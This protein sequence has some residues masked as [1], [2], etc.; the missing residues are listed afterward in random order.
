MEYRLRYRDIPWF[1]A[2]TV[3]PGKILGTVFIKWPQRFADNWTHNLV[4]TGLII[5]LVLGLSG[6]IHYVSDGEV[7]LFTAF[8]EW[9]GVIK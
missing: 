2:F 8:L 3:L 9:I 1:V 6:L 5:S 7:N 4:I